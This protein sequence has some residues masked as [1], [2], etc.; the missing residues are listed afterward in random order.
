MGLSFHRLLLFEGLFEVAS[1]GPGSSLARFL[2]SPLSVPRRRREKEAPSSGKPLAIQLPMAP[3]PS[4][5]LLKEPPGIARTPPA[6]RKAAGRTAAFLR[7]QSARG[8]QAPGCRLSPGPRRPPG[9][10]R[11]QRAEARA[12]GRPPRRRPAGGFRNRLC[13]PLEERFTNTAGA[14]WVVPAC[15]SAAK[16]TGI[17]FGERSVRPQQRTGGTWVPDL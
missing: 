14:P 17:D 10:P 6:D 3:L 13:S 1:L 12:S 7:F 4:R 11:S 16:S 5:L 9:L 2:S 8:S 15:A